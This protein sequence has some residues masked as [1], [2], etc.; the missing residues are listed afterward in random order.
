MRVDP[1]SDRFDTV[2]LDNPLNGAD[3]E[4]AA[5]TADKK[6]KV[7]ALQFDISP[8]ELLH[9]LDCIE[10]SCG[11]RDGPWFFAFCLVCEEVYES[12][13]TPSIVKLRDSQP[14]NLTDTQ[15]GIEHTEGHR[16]VAMS[17]AWFPCVLEFMLYLVEELH[18]L[19]GRYC[20]GGFLHLVSSFLL[21]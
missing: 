6:S 20:F 3:G 13:W 7:N 11:Y 5:G 15:S 17:S 2:S 21:I 12:P 9:F 18:L 1:A 16:V 8:V 10:K 14:H 19:G 4:W